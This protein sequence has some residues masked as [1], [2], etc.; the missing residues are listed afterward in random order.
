MEESGSDTI[1]SDGIM[2]SKLQITASVPDLYI[3]RV[4]EIYNHQTLQITASVPDL[5]I[6]RVQEIYNHQTNWNRIKIYLLS[7][8]GLGLV[9]DSNT[10]T[11]T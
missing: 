7:W 6:Q 10:C 1:S 3:H 2:I 8:L 5:Y 11:D 9:Q 4:Q